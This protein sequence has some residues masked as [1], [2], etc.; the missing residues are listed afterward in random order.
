MIGLEKH[1]PVSS[2]LKEVIKEKGKIVKKATDYEKKREE[3]FKRS[4]TLRM[5]RAVD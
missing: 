3:E 4:R 5:K 1:I 2:Y